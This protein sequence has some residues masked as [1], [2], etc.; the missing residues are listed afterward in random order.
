MRLL[1]IHI[2][3]ARVSVQCDP[4]DC[5]LRKANERSEVADSEHFLKKLLEC[6]VLHLLFL[7]KA[8]QSLNENSLLEHKWDVLCQL[9]NLQKR[10]KVEREDFIADWLWLNPYTSNQSTDV[11][12]FRKDYAV[13]ERVNIVSSNDKSNA[14]NEERTKLSVYLPT[15]MCQPKGRHANLLIAQ[16]LW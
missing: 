7:H 1:A 8:F 15:E 6:A 9:W 16:A 11:G 5:L 2:F 10:L 13:D 3:V 4:G 14:G 12:V